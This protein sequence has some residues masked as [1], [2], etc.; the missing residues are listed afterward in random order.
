MWETI[1]IMIGPSGLILL[2]AILVAIGGFWASV[3]NSHSQEKIV[4]L[5]NIIA[6]SITGGDSFCFL[7][8]STLDSG[9]QKDNPMVIVLQQGRFPVYDVSIRIKDQDKIEA[10]MKSESNWKDGLMLEHLNQDSIEIKPGVCPPQTAA[11]WGRLPLGTG[12]YRRFEVEIA[13]RN[14]LL[15]QQIRCKRVKGHW[16]IASKVTRNIGST[17]EVVY[18]R[19]AQEF[20]RNIKG[21]IEW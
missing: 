21:Q 15:H 8:L 3:K 12:N 13:A 18:E 14:G 7:A 20:P 16:K 4:E 2:G 10:V 1:K 6:S 5:N 11:M 19:I 9:P 17:S